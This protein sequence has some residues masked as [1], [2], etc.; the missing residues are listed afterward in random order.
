M[1]AAYIALAWLTADFITG[2]VHW[3]EDR[4]GNPDWPVIGK[5]V[6]APNILHH[7]DQR[8][9]L[10]GN[11]FTRNW[12]TFLPAFAASALFALAG[13]YWLALTAA[14]CGLGNEIHGW[15]HQKCNRLVRGLQLLGV[16]CS[17][18][19]HAVHHERPFDRYYCVMTSYLNPVLSTIRFWPA[20]ELIIGWTIRIWPREER[21]HA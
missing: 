19:D 16:F 5:Y 15:A 20:L 10:A 17:P 1:V 4:Y 9:F 6:V 18:E 7:E 14:F 3:W 21:A 2:V 11:F 12:T 13:L 8:A